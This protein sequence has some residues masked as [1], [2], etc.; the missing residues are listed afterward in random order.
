[1]SL[2]DCGVCCCATALGRRRACTRP[3]HPLLS[4]CRG[5][6]ILFSRFAG[7]PPSSSLAL[8][9]DPHPLLS[10]CRGT[11]ILFSRFAGGPPSSSL[12]LQGDPHTL[13]HLLLGKGTKGSALSTVE[14]CRDAGLF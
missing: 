3:P 11:P 4:L 12:A 13:E 1:M 2:R 6:P 9:G 5:T 8:Q 7:G 10:L 14:V